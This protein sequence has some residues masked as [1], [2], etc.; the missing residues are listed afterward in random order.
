MNKKPLLSICMPTY[1]RLKHI[2]R[3]VEYFRSELKSI[4]QGLVE[5]IISNND[6]K[7]GTYEFLE[8]VKDENITIH[9]NEENI[10]AY[11][12]MT[13]L[14]Y[15]ANGKY[16]WLPGDDDYLKKGLVKQ[17]LG[18][19]QQYDLS[20]L[21]L[22]RRVIR[23]NNKSVTEEGKTHCIEY[24]KPVKVEI[25]QITELLTE[26]YSD[27]RFQTSEIIKKEVALSCE[28]ECVHLSKMIRE[29]NFTTFRAIRSM[30]DGLSYFISDIVILSG[31]EITWKALQIDYSFIA[32]SQF[33]DYLTAFGFSKS[34]SRKI[35]KRQMAVNYAMALLNKDTLKELKKR[36]YPEWRISLMT[37]IIRLALRKVLRK[38]G[39]SS[40]YN[41]KKINLADF[42]INM[43]RH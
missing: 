41:T 25:R 10:G 32:D 27:F 34:Q 36:G 35:K 8:S 30:Q 7:D 9:H 40:H 39:L 31:D 22:S 3:Q 23:E 17:I 2:K 13:C 18:L 19:L 6:S 12:N 38:L 21:Y 14:L 4:D 24:D 42:G 11:G 26:N 29:S 28:R 16:F 33:I 1:N 15:L 37:I 5:V 43:G 20:F